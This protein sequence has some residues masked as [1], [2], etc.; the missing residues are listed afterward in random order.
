MKKPTLGALGLAALSLASAASAADMAVPSSGPYVAPPPAVA[1]PFYDWTGV[2]VGANGGW[3]QTHACWDQVLAGVVVVD[4]CHDVSGGMLGGQIGFRQQV[5]FWV[6]G[7]EAQ[8]DWVDINGSRTSVIN[9]AVLETTKV[10]GLGLFTAQG[11]YT[12][13]PAL[14]YFKGGAAVTRSRFDASAGGANLGTLNVTR[15]GGVVGVG[16]EYEFFKN[17]SAG[18]E[19]DH[20]FMG[21]AT[22]TFAG[23][24]PILPGANNQISQDVDMVTLRINYR[25]AGYTY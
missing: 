18:V 14:L 15:G 2:Y 5:G 7:V 19:Y 21:K 10:Q 8:G 22:S 13:G 12:W 4:G 6:W 17:W 24:N 1:R 25:F 3:A 9:P 23:V 20:L 16:F 11:G